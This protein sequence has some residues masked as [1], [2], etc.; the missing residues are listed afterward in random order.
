MPLAQSI[1]TMRRRVFLQAGGLSS[2]GLILPDLLRARNT[3]GVALR[4]APSAKACILLYMTGGPA[5]QETFDMKP[6]AP[7]APRGEFRPIPTSVPG[8]QICELLPLL[9]KQAHR[10]TVIRSTHHDQT[11]HGAGSHY[12]L[13]GF[14]HAPRDPTPEFYLD[15]RDCPSLGAVLQQLRGSR[16]G[17]PATVQ[18]PWW[19]GHGFVERFAG[20]HAGFLGPS[21][22]PLKIFYE[23]KKE[24]PGALPA[25]FRLPGGLAAAA[26][27]PRAAPR[28]DRAGSRDGQQERA[29]IR[30][31]PGSGTRRSQFLGRLASI[32][33]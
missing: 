26:V 18:L 7:E 11:F 29:A 27:A 31:V 17:L 8:T 13:T 21:Y 28:I 3:A 19:I 2:L 33:D 24:L 15:R 9:A 12:S 5:Q 1:L 10:Y 6:H 14:P 23:E 30:Q 25:S 32:L 20:Q 4:P 22:D 16:N